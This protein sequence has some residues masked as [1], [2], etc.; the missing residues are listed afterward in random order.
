M[1]IRRSPEQFLSKDVRFF[2]FYTRLVAEK[3][4][5]IRTRTWVCLKIG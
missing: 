1:W 4:L 5:V 3:G 2:S